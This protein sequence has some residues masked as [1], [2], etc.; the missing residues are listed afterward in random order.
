MAKL[1]TGGYEVV[2]LG[3]SWH[4][5]TGGAGSVSYGERPQGLRRP[6][7]P[8]V[9]VIPEPNAYRCPVQPLPRTSAT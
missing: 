3:G 2:G 1:Y 5:V 9:F 4:G 8:G 7:M 6:G